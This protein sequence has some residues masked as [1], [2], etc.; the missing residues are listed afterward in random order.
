MQQHGK[1]HT[2]ILVLFFRLSWC[3]STLQ[4]ELSWFNLTSTFQCCR[5]A[6]ISYLDV[7]GPATG[8]CLLVKNIVRYH[9]KSK[10][11]HQIINHLLCNKEIVYMGKCG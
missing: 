2:F 9:Q 7:Q 8:L 6:Q 11:G 1:R 4:G 3:L 10:F 5:M